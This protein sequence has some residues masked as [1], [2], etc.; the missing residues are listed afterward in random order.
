VHIV[1]VISVFAAGVP[2]SPLQSVQR[3]KREC[4]RRRG[5]DAPTDQHAHQRISIGEIR[6]WQWT[7]EVTVSRKNGF[8]HSTG[9]RDGSGSFPEF[10]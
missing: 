6:V 9:A 8:R 10:S 2:L 4:R 1:C 7:S 5:R 3:G